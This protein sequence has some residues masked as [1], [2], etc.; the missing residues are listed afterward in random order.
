MVVKDKLKIWQQNLNKSPSCQHNLLS[1][2]K[3]I[4]INI[5]VVALQEPAI[6]HNNL[7]IAVKD[8]ITVYPSTHGSKPKSTRALT[9]ISV[10]IST[11]D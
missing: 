4:K 10:Q 6:N 9:L 2:D 8:W 11:E 3:L 7:S 1:S 5:D